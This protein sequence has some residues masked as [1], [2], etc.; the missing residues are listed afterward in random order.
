MSN[1]QGNH[2]SSLSK[3]AQYSPSATSTPAFLAAPGPLFDCRIPRSQDPFAASHSLVPSFDPSSTTTI[4]KL[5]NDCS[6]TDWT[7]V[8]RN[9]SLSCVGMITENSGG[10]IM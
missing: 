3:K 6:L 9:S 4:S 7:A 10:E 2:K 5:E 8:L 1:V